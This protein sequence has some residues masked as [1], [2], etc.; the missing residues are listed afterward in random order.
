MGSELANVRRRRRRFIQILLRSSLTLSALLMASGLS[1]WLAGADRRAPGTTP[2][3]LL[4][5]LDSGHRLMIAGILMLTLTPALSVVAL[6]VLWTREGL[7]RFAGTAGLVLALLG[8][9]LWLGGR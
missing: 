6:L 8:A 4:E 9:A 2:A 1:F 3:D 7:W 5:T